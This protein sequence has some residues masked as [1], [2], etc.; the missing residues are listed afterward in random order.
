MLLVKRKKDLWRGGG[1]GDIRSPSIDNSRIMATC[2][3]Q[4]ERSPAGQL[5][6]CAIRK[7]V[8]KSRGCFE[9]GFVVVE[10]INV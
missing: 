6:R 10:K 3:L 2:G 9:G 5:G 7:V 1:E 4:E 8:H